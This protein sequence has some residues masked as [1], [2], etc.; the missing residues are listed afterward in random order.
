[1]LDEITYPAREG[2]EGPPDEIKLLYEN[3]NIPVP[4]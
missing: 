3:L 1:M 4:V 2:A